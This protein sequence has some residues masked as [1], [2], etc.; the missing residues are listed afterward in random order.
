MWFVIAFLTQGFGDL[1]FWMIYM[2]GI[3]NNWFYSLNR[4]CY[5]KWNWSTYSEWKEMKH[6]HST[7]VERSQREPLCQQLKIIYDFHEYGNS[8]WRNDNDQGG[9]I[10]YPDL[11]LIKWRSPDQ[12]A[13][14]FSPSSKS[15]IPLYGQHGFRLCFILILSHF[16]DAVR[17]IA[18]GN[19]VLVRVPVRKANSSQSSPSL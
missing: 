4:F 2:Q 5:S 19:S 3:R 12:C 9:T 14:I 18:W 17:L 16:H 7:A 8:I 1:I 15:F 11:R 6:G 10:W 13:P